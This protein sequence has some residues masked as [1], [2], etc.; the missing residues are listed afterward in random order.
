MEKIKVMIVDDSAL[1]RK[2]IMEILQKDEEIEIVA[3]AMNG[4]FALNKLKM[5]KP[6]VITL[7]IEMPQMNGLEFLEEKRKVGDTTPVIVFSSLTSEGSSTTMKAIELGAKDYLLKPDIKI[8]S[9]LS[10]IEEEMIQ[11]I[12]SW[13]SKNKNRTVDLSNIKIQKRKNI[14]LEIRE[15]NRIELLSNPDKIKFIAIGISTGGPE[16]LRQILPKFNTKIPI[17]IIQHMPEG[18]TKDFANSLNRITNPIGYISK[19]IEN[20]EILKE[21]HIYI[22]PGNHQLSIHKSSSNFILK[23]NKD[24]PVNNHRPSVDYF[25]STLYKNIEENCF[26]AIIMTG[27]GKD[28]AFYIKKLHDRGI[29]T[30]AQDEESC[31]VFGMPKTAIE[32]QGVDKILSLEK[33]PEFINEIKKDK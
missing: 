2:L 9:D 22:A 26:V 8:P 30:I 15:T 20:N 24:P 7:D 17:I 4:L 18:F 28:G 12:K 6:D 31:I 11:K 32:L 5:L 19:E 10:N 21:Q 27:M 3:T 33:I 29:F 25:F 13:G 16:A 14:E 23:I 1:M